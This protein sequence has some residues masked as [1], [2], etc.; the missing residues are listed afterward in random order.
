MT[1]SIMTL[2]IM[3]L[4]IMTL[5][6]MT[7]SLMAEF[8]YA[9]SFML[10]V[11][12]AQSHVCSRVLSFMLGVIMLNVVMPSAAILTVFSLNETG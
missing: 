12:Y 9:V 8:Y 10:K 6:I 3:I 1:L 4:S 5:R 11:I 2:S 7:F